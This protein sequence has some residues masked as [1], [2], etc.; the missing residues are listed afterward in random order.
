[1]LGREVQ[2][3]VNENQNAGTHFVNFNAENFASGVYLY[4]LESGAFVQV[5]KM[6]FM[7]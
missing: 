4:R 2:T 5:K 7:K 3:L 1:M 6:I